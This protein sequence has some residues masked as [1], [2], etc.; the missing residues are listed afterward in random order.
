MPVIVELPTHADAQAGIA[1]V[2]VGAQYR[3]FRIQLAEAVAY[4]RAQPQRVDALVPKS[5]ERLSAKANNRQRSSSTGVCT[6]TP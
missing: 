1:N 5:T 2:V 6:S 3:R 4:A